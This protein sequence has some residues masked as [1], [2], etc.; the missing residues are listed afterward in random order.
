M[1]SQET[2]NRVDFPFSWKLDFN[3]TAGYT[4]TELTECIA[5]RRKLA[6]FSG[7]VTHHIGILAI[8]GTITK[9]TNIQLMHSVLNIF[10]CLPLIIISLLGKLPGKNA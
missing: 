10:C 3:H 8:A 2:F 5:R 9:I 1:A 4:H 6:F 7:K